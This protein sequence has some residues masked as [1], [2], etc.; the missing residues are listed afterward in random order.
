M[1][2]KTDA[3]PAVDENTPLTETDALSYWNQL[4][5]GETETPTPATTEQAPA[6]DEAAVEGEAGEQTPELPQELR[7]ALTKVDSLAELVSTLTHQVKSS[8]GR[9]AAVQ[10]ELTAAKTASQVVTRAPNQQT[11]QAAAKT[12]EAWAKLKDQFPDWAEAI[13]AYGSHLIA[14]VPQPQQ[15]DLAPIQSQFAEQLDELRG[16]ITRSSEEAKLYGAYRGWKKDINSPEFSTWLPT[17]SAEVQAK[18]RSP[19]A[20]DAI[21]V[22]D[23]YHTHSKDSKR[24]ITAERTQRLQAAVGRPKGQATPPADDRDLTDKQIWAQEATRRDQRRAAANR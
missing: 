11:V 21:D 6:A 23:A 7:A 1:V 19:N 10:R 17:Q 3:A 5:A 24:D 9:F 2:K 12:P 20:D 18:F 4:A 13:E 16:Q 15:I 8:E 14:G 22:L